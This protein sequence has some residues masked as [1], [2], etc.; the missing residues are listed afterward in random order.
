MALTLALPKS[1]FSKRLCTLAYGPWHFL[2][3][4]I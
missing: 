3:R 4:P 1:V 2:N